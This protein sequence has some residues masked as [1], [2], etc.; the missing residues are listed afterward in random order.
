MK[1]ASLQ[2]V[3]RKMK[4]LDLCMLI[5]QDGRQSMRARPMSNNG[6]VKYDGTTW[7]FTYDGSAK[8][9]QIESNSKV[10]LLYQRGERLFIHCSGRASVVRTKRLIEEKW[11]DSLY[12]WF[13]D[14]PETD[15]ICLLKVTATRVHVWDGGDESEYRA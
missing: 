14:G 12:Q 13:P 10:S 9:S 4:N 8:V 2:A 6:K 3:A 5:T 11:I 15:G 7:F 1:R